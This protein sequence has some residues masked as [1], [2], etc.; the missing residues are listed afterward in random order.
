MVN[1]N[2]SAFDLAKFQTTTADSSDGG[3]SPQEATDGKVSNDSRWYSNSSSNPHWLQ[4]DLSRPYPVG[5]AQLFLGKDDS[6]TVGSFEIQYHESGNWH[7]IISVANNTATDLNLVFPS[8]VTAQTFRFY[9]TQNIA[10]IKEFVL[11]PPNNGNPHPLGT[12]I[13][14]NLIDERGP[15]ASSTNGSNFPI[16][17][18]DGWVDDNSRWLVGNNTEPHT[19]EFEIPTEHEVGSLHLYSGFESNGQTSGVLDAFD[20][21]YANGSG[22]TPIP[23]G[24]VSSGAITGNSVSG[25]TSAELVVN[26]SSPVSATKFRLT[27][28]KAYGR[29]REVVVLPANVTD[30]GDVGYPVGTSVEFAPRPSTNFKDYHDSWYRIAARSNNNSLIVS[31]TGATQADSSTADE[32]KNFQLLYIKSLD[33]YRIRN[34]DSG[35]GIEVKDASLDAGAQIVEGD[36]SAA[37]H[38]LWKLQP[39]Q[40]GYFQIVNVWSG[41]VLETDSGSPAIVTQQTQDTSSNPVNGQEWIAFFQDDYFKREPEVGLANMARRGVTTGPAMI[42]TAWVST[43]FTPQCS[44]EKAG[45]T[46]HIA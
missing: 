24:T 23:G 8:V 38:Q 14:L 41:L 35:R 46:S 33:A 29:I 36:Y 10:R 37:P 19:I 22:W 40:N 18:V 12:D 31:D 17:A 39:T 34:Q 43:N 21:E 3:T 45:R 5:S 20:I 25:N 1:S 32:E 11:L 6:F 2:Y 9:T 16:K 26:F 4:V 42:M 7:T 30:N 44:T 15:V 13:D 27:H 28:A